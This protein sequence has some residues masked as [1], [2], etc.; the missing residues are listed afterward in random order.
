MV[1]L[2]RMKYTLFHSKGPM[3]QDI[4][5]KKKDLREAAVAVHQSGKGYKVVPSCG[6]H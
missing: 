6:K 5:K 1:Q 2:W 4:K 3:Y